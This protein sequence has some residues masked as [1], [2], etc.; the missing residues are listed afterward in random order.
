MI[1]NADRIM[2]VTKDGIAEEGSHDELIEQDGILQS[3]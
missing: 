1:K 2:V 3:S